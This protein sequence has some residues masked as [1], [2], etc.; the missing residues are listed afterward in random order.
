[1]NKVVTIRLPRGYKSAADFARDCG[2]E[3]FSAF[4]ENGRSGEIGAWQ[5]IEI[6]PKDGTD[7][8]VYRPKFD[9]NYIPMVGVD[10]WSERLG[11]VWAKSRK[12]TPPTHWVSLPAPPS[13]TID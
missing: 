9:G 13:H 1:M 5:P 2:V 12:D 4:A 7:I 6:A 11:G 3:V 8:I 10:Y